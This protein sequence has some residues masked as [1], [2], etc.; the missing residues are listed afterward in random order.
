LLLSE[1]VLP[2]AAFISNGHTTLIKAF[3]KHGYPK[4]TDKTKFI[5]AGILKICNFNQ[6]FI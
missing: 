6:P 3:P 2:G 1:P 4:K 5:F